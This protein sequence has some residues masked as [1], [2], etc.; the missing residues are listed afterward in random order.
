MRAAAPGARFCTSTSALAKSWSSTWAAASCFT[1]R[2]RLSF[3]RLVQTK[4]DARP[5]TRSS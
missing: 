3:E 4:C 2:L 1:S 5:S